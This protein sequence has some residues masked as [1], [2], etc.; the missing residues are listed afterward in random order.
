M[1]LPILQKKF[2]NRHLNVRAIKRQLQCQQL[3]LARYQQMLSI[4]SERNF[5]TIMQELRILNLA[6]QIR[7]R[8]MRDGPREEMQIQEDFLSPY[9]PIK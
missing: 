9:G 8:K 6:V 2:N 1:L 5:G 4:F 3:L 7:Q